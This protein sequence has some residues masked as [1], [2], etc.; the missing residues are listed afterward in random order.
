MIRRPRMGRAHQS[1][2][3]LRDEPLPVWRPSGRVLTRICILIQR[4]DVHGRNRRSELHFRNEG[5]R[6][7]SKSQT[8]LPSITAVRASYGERISRSRV[9]E[10]KIK[11]GGFGVRRGTCGTP[12]QSDRIG[13]HQGREI[14]LPADEGDGTDNQETLRYPYRNPIRDDRSTRRLDPNDRLI[15]TSVLRTSIVSTM[16]RILFMVLFFSSALLFASS[17]KQIETVH[18]TIIFEEDEREA[19]LQVASFADEIFEELSAL[20]EN[21]TIKRAGDPLRA[22]RL[23]QRNVRPFPSAIT[24]YLASDEDQFW[25]RKP[26]PG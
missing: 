7:S 17:W 18:T 10:R 9:E 20:L 16:K 14:F 4:P 25:E 24:L 26:H 21:P 1:G 22:N 23:G 3:E 6:S 8:I 13:Y 5:R 2:F 11:L 15:C 19:A 12:R